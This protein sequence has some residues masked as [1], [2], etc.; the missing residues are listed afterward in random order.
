L[1]PAALEGRRMCYESTIFTKFNYD[2]QHHG[3]ISVGEL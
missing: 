2:F 3:A 1:R